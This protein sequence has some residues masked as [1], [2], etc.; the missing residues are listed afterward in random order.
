MP[1][2]SGLRKFRT[3][4]YGKND[5]QDSSFFF[6]GKTWLGEVIIEGLLGSGYEHDSIWKVFE[7]TLTDLV[8]EVWTCSLSK[9]GFGRE[10]SFMPIDFTFFW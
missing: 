4:C 1:K 9:D 10:R 8:G 3:R 2:V 7:G 5:H 6:F